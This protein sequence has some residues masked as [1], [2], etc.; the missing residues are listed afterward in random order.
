MGIEQTRDLLI[1]STGFVGTNLS[2]Q[3][4]FAEFANSKNIQEFAGRQYDTIVCAGIT[5]MKWWANK[6]PIEDWQNIQSLLTVLETV[7]ARRFMLISTVDVYPHPVNVDEFVPL[8][9]LE[10]HHYGRHRLRVETAIAKRFAAHHIVRLPALFGAG[11]KKNVIFDLL[12]NN[13]L[14]SINPASSFQY[15]HLDGLWADLQRV[16]AANLPL[17]NFATEP[18]ETAGIIGR[19][20]PGKPVGTKPSPPAHYDFRT[21]Y[22]NLWGQPGDYIYSSKQVLDDLAHFVASQCG[23]RKAK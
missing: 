11:L 20:F 17:V 23:G 3:H 5:A 6:N 21:R 1:G 12:H 4:T 10:N 13:C 14:E 9:S 8:E 7:E 16:V 18:V 19:F 22:A 15:Y 2:R